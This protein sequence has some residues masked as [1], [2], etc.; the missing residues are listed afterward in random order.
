M[1][2]VVPLASPLEGHCLFCGGHGGISC[3]GRQCCQTDSW[4]IIL[5]GPQ[6]WLYFSGSCQ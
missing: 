1:V 5:E 6:Q 3:L 4:R 2:L